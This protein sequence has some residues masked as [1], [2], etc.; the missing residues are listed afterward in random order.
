MRVSS[1]ELFSTLKSRWALHIASSKEGDWFWPSRSTSSE[2]KLGKLLSKQKKKRKNARGSLKNKQTNKQKQLDR[3]AECV[4]VRLRRSIIDLVSHSHCRCIS[5]SVLFG[6]FIVKALIRSVL[7]SE[8]LAIFFWQGPCWSKLFSDP[9]E[10]FRNRH[11]DSASIACRLSL[12]LNCFSCVVVMGRTKALISLTVVETKNEM[13]VQIRLSR[14]CNI[15]RVCMQ[16]VESSCACPVVRREKFA[17]PL[18]YANWRFSMS[19]CSSKLTI[20]KNGGEGLM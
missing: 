2:S 7:F 18:W 3:H 1:K 15:F 17:D 4:H 16:A 5:I 13:Q 20:K 14:T 6:F 8:K 19:N 12:W 9:L 10:A 11:V